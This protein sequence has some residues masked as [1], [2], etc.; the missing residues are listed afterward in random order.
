MI[1]KMLFTGIKGV[2]DLLNLL[3]IIFRFN[4]KDVTEEAFEAGDRLD[5]AVQGAIE[6]A[7]RKI[8]VH[9]SL[10]LSFISLAVFRIESQM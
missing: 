8:K 7:D 4:G 5:I 10:L 9:I 6:L 2:I 3:T 1:M